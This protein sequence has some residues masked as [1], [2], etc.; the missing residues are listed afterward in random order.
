MYIFALDIISFLASITA[1]VIVLFSTRRFSSHTFK[2]AALAVTGL[3]AA[4]TF[5]LC[6]EWGGFTSTF[7]D[8]EDLTG[9]LLPVFM[10][11]SLFGLMEHR[12]SSV[13]A[14][15]E[16][17][18][19]LA[20]E[21]AS[22]ATWD[23]DLYS[24]TVCCNSKWYTMAGAKPILRELRLEEWEA[25]IHPDDLPVLQKSI[26]RHL[27]G[28]TEGIEIQHRIGKIPGEWAW[29]ITK[30][31]VISPERL[32]G[33]SLDINE[34]KKMEE[35]LKTK[36]EEYHAANEELSESLESIRLI[37]IQLEEAKEKA[38]ESDRLKTSFLA[39]LSHEI[40]TPMNGILGFADLLKHGGLQQSVQDEYI[41]VIQQSG[42][43]MLSL[44]EDLVNISKIEAGQVE[45]VNHSFCINELCRKCFKFFKPEADKKNIHFVFKPGLGTGQSSVISDS[46]RLEQVVCNLVKN[47]LKFTSSGIVEFGYGV[48]GAEIIF[49]VK[50]T[51]DGI[52]AESQTSIFQRFRRADPKKGK[53]EEGCGLGLAISKAFVELMGG[54][55]WLDSKPG[56]GS[57]FY[58]SLPYKPGTETILVEPTIQQPSISRKATALIA[59][60]DQISFLL[61]REIL[62][63]QG[64]E[65]IHAKNGRM[66]VDLFVEN[67]D[68]DLVLMDVKMP[69]MNGLDATKQIRKIDKSVPI[70]AQTAYASEDDR[71]KAIDAGCN[72]TVSKPVNAKD[73]LVKISRLVR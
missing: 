3:L 73:L 58:F 62:N 15:S 24:G 7:D 16:Q 37:N 51:G 43:R 70:I 33:T 44:I 9:T 12:A 35:E 61:I 4:Y 26:R 21:G 1:F 36:N 41:E 66:A 32:A 53:N 6:L 48:T 2:F 40:R 25:Y 13:L 19:M 63:H 27:K 49:Y 18:V 30:G 59:E 50:D 20:V 34:R 23:W 57:C 69:V 45:I 54:K 71:E 22:L 60:D 31:K 52:A 14:Q 39:N 29:V 17:R 65:V 68:I 28:E 47:A 56:L 46:L 67:R 64:W 8:W 38:E 42:R 11:L 5:M 72:D 55:I 10:L